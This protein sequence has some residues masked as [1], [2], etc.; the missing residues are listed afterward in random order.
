MREKRSE[1]IES[2]SLKIEAN[3]QVDFL[4]QAASL[5]WLL[6]LES[7]LR[8]IH[9]RTDTVSHMAGKAGS[10]LRHL[11]ANATRAHIFTLR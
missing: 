3:T 9:V 2:Q 4:A 5:A 10:G 6:A 7:P 8:N 11:E 1:R